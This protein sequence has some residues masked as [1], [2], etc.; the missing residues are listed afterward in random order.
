MVEIMTNDTN[1]HSKTYTQNRLKVK[2]S[3]TKTVSAVFFLN[4]VLLTNLITGCAINDAGFVKVKHFENKTVHMVNLKAYGCFLSTNEADAGLT[5]GFIE[6]QYFYP[7]NK[8]FEEI[9][10]SNMLLQAKGDRLLVQEKGLVSNDFSDKAIAWLTKT[11]GLSINTNS[12]R[13]G[14]SLGLVKSQAI[15]LSREFD[16]VFIFKHIADGDTR[17]FYHQN[18]PLE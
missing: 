18:K 14:I 9:D 16:G 2:V 3:A 17:V 8:Q 11:E 7:K 4:T 6:R 15:K 12:H 13:M 5:I 10:L 1:I